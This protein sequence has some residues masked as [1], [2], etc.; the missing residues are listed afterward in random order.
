MP[1]CLPCSTVQLSPNFLHPATE[2]PS[3]FCCSASPLALPLFRSTHSCAA[4]CQANLRS[5]PQLRPWHLHQRDLSSS[6]KPRVRLQTSAEFQQIDKPKH[7]ARHPPRFRSAQWG[8]PSCSPQGC[9]AVRPYTL[10]APRLLRFKEQIGRLEIAVTSICC[11]SRV[12]YVKF[13]TTVDFRIS[14]T[15]HLTRTAQGSGV[16]KSSILLEKEFRLTPRPFL[17]L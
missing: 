15:L 2:F 8:I 9:I 16:V 12:S 4:L 14:C 6:P 13:T 1:L 11:W 3:S 17:R 5:N 10:T 7:R